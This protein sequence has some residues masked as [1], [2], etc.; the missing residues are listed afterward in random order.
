M[1]VWALRFGYVALG[2]AVA[3]LIVL[4]SGGTPWLLFAGVVSWLIV[5][6]ITLTG[7]LWARRELPEPRPRLWSMRGM[8]LH[9]TVRARAPASGP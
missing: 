3:G 5:V 6:V 8:L 4:L 7:F 9:D 1:A 2:V